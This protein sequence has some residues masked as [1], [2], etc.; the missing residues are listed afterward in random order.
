MVFV[1]EV[2]KL[3]CYLAI[4]VLSIRLIFLAREMKRDGK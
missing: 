1:L 4:L 3:I 2:I